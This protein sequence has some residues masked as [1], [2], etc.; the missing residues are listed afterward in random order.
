LVYS[1]LLKKVYFSKRRA[2][3]RYKLFPKKGKSRFIKKTFRNTPPPSL[4]KVESIK[5]ALRPKNLFFPLVSSPNYMEISFRLFS[6]LV[7]RDVHSAEI[8][9]PFSLRDLRSYSSGAQIA[10]VNL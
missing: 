1:T 4:T 5:S 2:F 9:I 3:S 7:V 10:T 6:I 8:N